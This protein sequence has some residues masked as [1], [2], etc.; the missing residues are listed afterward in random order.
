MSV[1]LSGQKNVF[2]CITLTGAMNRCD[3]GVLYP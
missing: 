3:T 1:N 2:P